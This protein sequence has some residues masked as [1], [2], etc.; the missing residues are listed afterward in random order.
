MVSR[1][2]YN[3]GEDGV[4]I[5]SGCPAESNEFHRRFNSWKEPVRI[6]YADKK[7]AIQKKY[8]DD[9]ILQEKVQTYISWLSPAGLFEQIADIQCY[10]SSI[11][12]LRFM[13]HCRIYREEIIR[14]FKD[15][16]L[17]ESYLY[18]TPQPESDF[19]TQEECDRIEEIIDETDDWDLAPKEWN[20]NNYPPLDLSDV[21]VFNYKSASIVSALNASFSRMAGL[22]ALCIIILIA[23]K[24]SFNKFDVK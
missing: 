19:P 6:D 23:T 1:W 2:Y 22:F 13:E 10:T 15:K 4:E 16:K 3:G 20:Y 5:M 8:L 17:F 24:L 11:T 18:F 12:L 9:L 7:W 14:Y 21:P